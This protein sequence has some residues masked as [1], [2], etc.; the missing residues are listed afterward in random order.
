MTVSPN[1][2]PYP[3]LKLWRNSSSRQPRFRGPRKVRVTER[4]EPQK[5]TSLKVVGCFL[6]LGLATPIP[7]PR[8]AR[9]PLIKEYSLNH[10]IKAAF[11]KVYSGIRGIGLSGF[12]SGLMCSVSS[13]LCMTRT[14]G[15]PQRE[16]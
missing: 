15:T 14:P 5:R 8:R 1:P 13:V 9:Y 4:F 12:F 10:N 11:F 3:S 7:V 2:K 16:C 6:K